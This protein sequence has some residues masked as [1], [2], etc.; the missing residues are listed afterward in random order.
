MPPK[1]KTFHH[2]ISPIHFKICVQVGKGNW[3]KVPSYKLYHV[4]FFFWRRVTC[5]F[6]FPASWD[7][8][9]SIQL[10]NDAAICFFGGEKMRFC[11]SRVLIKFF[12]RDI[13]LSLVNYGPLQ[14]DV[15]WA[16]IRSQFH[17]RIALIPFVFVH[18]RS[19]RIKSRWK[20]YLCELTHVENIFAWVNPHSAILTGTRNHIWEKSN[21]HLMSLKGLFNR[22]FK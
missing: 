11:F 13:F 15:D 10:V 1:T 18:F 2:E 5:F 3:Y 22:P 21:N 9:E 17:G 7:Q 8:C 19:T 6:L 14:R 4:I 12:K 20:M 16:W